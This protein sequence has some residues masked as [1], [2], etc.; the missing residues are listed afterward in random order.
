VKP[1]GEAKTNA[2]YVLDFLHAE[3]TEEIDVALK[4]HETQALMKPVD[5][6]GYD[7][8]YVLMPIRS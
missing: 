3:R 6:T 5:P 1:T 2:G 7:Y 4:D 8:S